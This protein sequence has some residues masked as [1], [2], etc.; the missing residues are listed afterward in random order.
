MRK[1]IPLQGL[2][3][4]LLLAFCPISADDSK[5]AL[6]TISI[7]SLKSREDQ[8]ELLVK[9]VL[10]CTVCVRSANGMGSG[11]GVVVSE[12]GL[13]LTAA[14]VMQAAGR[15]LVVIFPD[16]RGAGKTTRCQSQSRCRDGSDLGGRHVRVL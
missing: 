6:G 8:V 14:H 5:P 11:S 1:Q 10:P 15:D 3:L 13:V 2:L 7:K 9:K 12:D 4:V 16:G